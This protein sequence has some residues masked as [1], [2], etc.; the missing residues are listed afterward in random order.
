MRKAMIRARSDSR[1]HQTDSSRST[2]SSL[3]CLHRMEEV[4][5]SLSMKGCPPHS[6]LANVCRAWKCPQAPN[7]NLILPLRN[8]RALHLHFRDQSGFR[9]SL[10]ALDAQGA[11]VLQHRVA[12]FEESRARRWPQQNRHRRPSS[13]ALPFRHRPPRAPAR[14]AISL[15]HTQGWLHRMG[16]PPT[17]SVG[18][19]MR[20]R[21]EKLHCFCA[22]LCAS[23]ALQAWTAAQ[24]R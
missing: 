4:L 9:C 18:L 13:S 6:V 2:S 5:D 10:L 15:L 8:L 22:L 19:P 20:Q 14:V 7:L 23:Q 12:Q 21:C 16:D 11:A 3:R 17:K 24:N 1:Q